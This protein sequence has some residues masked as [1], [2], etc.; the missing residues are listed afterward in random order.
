MEKSLAFPYQK[1]TNLHAVTR[2]DLAPLITFLEKKYQMIENRTKKPNS[3]KDYQKTEEKYYSRVKSASIPIF[4]YSVALL[5]IY[6]AEMYFL[7]RLLN[8]IGFAVVGIYTFLLV[9]FYFSFYRTK[10]RFAAQFKTPYYL[11]KLEFSETDLLD[12][13]GEFTDKLLAQFGY[14][15]LGKNAKF[16]ILEQSETNLLKNSLEKKRSQPEFQ[17]TFESE[18]RKV[19][20]ASNLTPKY[21]GKYSSFLDDP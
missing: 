10:K 2:L 13:R 18:Q 17:N 6:F 4:G 21:G 3:V 1:S 9:S 12:F 15:C 14:E 5:V 8:T 16:G 11:Q 20:T 7:L 19:K